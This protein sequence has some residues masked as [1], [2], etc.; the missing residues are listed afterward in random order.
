MRK[1]H[2]TIGLVLGLVAFAACAIFWRDASHPTM[3]SMAGIAMLMAVWWISEAV[4]L[5]VTALLPIA[6]FPF[7]GIMNANTAATL[8]FNKLIFLFVGGFIIA[9]AMKKCNLHRR[10]ALGIIAMIGS[11]PHQIVLGFMCATAF[12]S[13]WISNTAAAVMMVPIAMSVIEVLRQSSLNCDDETGLK[14]QGPDNFA[15]TL[16][17]GIAY[18]ASIGGVATLIGTPT[19]LILPVDWRR[20]TRPGSV[21]TRGADRRDRI[22][23][24]IFDGTHVQHGHHQCA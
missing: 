17:L 15:L 6:L 20:V 23:G 24:D 19:N 12:L 5:P 14:G 11:R 1:T 8:F 3:G 10:I 9:L 2:Q 4:P 16:M 13:M 21:P 7:L 22:A 18:A